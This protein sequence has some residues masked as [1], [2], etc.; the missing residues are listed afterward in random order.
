MRYFLLTFGILLSTGC[1]AVV[2][3]SGVYLPDVNTREQVHQV[4]GTPTSAGEQDGNMFEEFRTHRKLS[5]AWMGEYYLFADLET[6]F[7]IELYLF[8]RE[9][10]RAGRQRIMGQTLRFTYDGEGN[11]DHVTAN[12]NPLWVPGAY[13][14]KLSDRSQHTQNAEATAKETVS[15]GAAK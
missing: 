9:L 15:S 7:L 8:P 3:D 2:N 14:N 1:A 5:Q 11:V 13:A 12:G 4:F 6:L 10:W